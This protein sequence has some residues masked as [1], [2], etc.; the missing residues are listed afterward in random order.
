MEQHKRKPMNEFQLHPKLMADTIAVEEWRLS[1]L[2]MMNDARYPWFILVPRKTEL[3]E[4]FDLPMAERIVLM[5]EMSILA[6]A[7][8]ETFKPE[9]IN[10]GAFGNV[11]PQLHVHVIARFKG[12]P[13]WPNPIWGVGQPQHYDPARADEMMRRVR[14]TLKHR[15]EPK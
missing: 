4:I 8:D 9:K 14:E 5:E 10:I 1:S 15:L 11:V 12:D 3:R 7:L 6:K 13:A 2:R